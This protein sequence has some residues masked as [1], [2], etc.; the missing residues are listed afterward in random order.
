MGQS[1]ISKTP[2]RNITCD[3]VLF[4]EI[5]VVHS[6]SPTEKEVLKKHTLNHP[7][8]ER[9]HTPKFIL[10][11]FCAERCPWVLHPTLNPVTLISGLDHQ[12]RD[13]PSEFNPPTL[14]QFSTA[15][16]FAT[17][18]TRWRSHCTSFAGN[19]QILGQGLFL[20]DGLPYSSATL[21]AL[22]MHD[23]SSLYNFTQCRLVL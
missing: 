2:S 12:A 22:S 5:N 4:V 1:R 14:C 23:S 16:S 21:C 20:D 18:C 19:C 15:R 13:P 9:D 10:A 3:L 7:S 8:C 17:L 11:I 6:G